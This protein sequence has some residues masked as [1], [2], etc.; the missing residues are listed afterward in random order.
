VGV[1]V[2]TASQP[3][4]SKTRKCSNHELHFNVQ[5]AR[6]SRVDLIEQDTLLKQNLVDGVTVC[7]E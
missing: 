7:S 1:L 4:E 6:R 3:P 5:R 2:R